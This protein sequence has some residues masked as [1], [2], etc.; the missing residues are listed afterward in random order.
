[1]IGRDD[2]I[3]VAFLHGVESPDIVEELRLLH[4]LTLALDKSESLSS[5][6]AIV[7]KEV[8][9]ATG[10]VL[11]DAWVPSPDGATLTMGPAWH[12]GSDPLRKFAVGSRAYTFEPG[13]GY[14][15]GSGRRAS[16]SG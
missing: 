9:R 14:P 11:G 16:R 1:V 10:W 3:A 15:D 12:I 13:R 6:L 7:L 4:A 8:C 2:G 5:A